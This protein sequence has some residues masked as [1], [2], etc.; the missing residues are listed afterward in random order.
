MRYM[1]P[2]TTQMTT[3]RPAWARLLKAS[4]SLNGPLNDNGPV[5]IRVSVNIGLL[6][7]TLAF[8]G[9]FNVSFCR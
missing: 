1:R 2:T 5:K 6:K 4:L 8:N 9:Q 3:C 7:I